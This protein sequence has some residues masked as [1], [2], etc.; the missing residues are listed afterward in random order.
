MNAE[1]PHRTHHQLNRALD[2]H[3]A[4]LLRI[5]TRRGKNVAQGK[6]DVVA[7]IAEVG[8]DA[9]NLGLVRRQIGIRRDKL[10][11]EFFDDKFGCRWLREQNVQHRVTI[12]I[13][14]FAEHCLDAIVVHHWTE[15]KRRVVVKIDA[16]AGVSARRFLDVGLAVIAFAEG[17]QFHHLAREILVRR[18]LAVGGGVQI[19]DHRRVFGHGMQQLTEIAQ[20]VFAQQHI[21]AIHQLW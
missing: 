7:R 21:L 8:G 5:K 10:A 9:A 16:P 12:E 4:I 11:P 15:T 17:E 1:L 18:R 19:N 20:C 14:G 13:A 6:L 2:Q 3:C